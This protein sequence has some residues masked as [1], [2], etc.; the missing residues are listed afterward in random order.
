MLYFISRCNRFL[1]LGESMCDFLNNV[2]PYTYVL[3]QI[4]PVYYDSHEEI[5]KCL[6]L[7]P[8]DIIYSNYFLDENIYSG[9]VIGPKYD[10]AKMWDSKIYQYDK[11]RDIV[12]VPEYLKFDS[13]YDF[14]R[15]VPLNIPYE[16][17]FI[18][19]EY[20]EGGTN[21]AVYK[22]GINLGDVWKR[23]PQRNKV[24]VSNFLEDSMEISTHIVIFDNDIFICNMLKQYNDVDSVS[25]KILT[26]PIW[27]NDIVIEKAIDSIMKIGE[28]MR[29][30]GY[31]GI[32]GIDLLY[33]NNEFFLC[34]INPRK[35]GSSFFDDDIIHMEYG[36]SLSAL[37]FMAVNGMPIPQYH[38]DP[39]KLFFK[40]EML[41][42]NSAF[43][44][45]F[46]DRSYN[47]LLFDGFR[48]SK[49]DIKFNDFYNGNY[50]TFSLVGECDFT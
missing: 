39:F 18:T 17:M 50:K 7:S 36:Y 46:Y 21:N 25:F 26:Y 10:I 6:S 22:K 27:L 40:F 29:S 4:D 37:E 13:L 1:K 49:F 28:E 11:L 43:D 32:A 44:S 34:E 30:T 15:N 8:D 48:D 31:R 38:Y 19:S 16:K 12:N 41:P 23:V 47:Q 9:K 24:R 42:Y 33:H 5:N 35:M 3:K 2:G 20:S 45:A 14:L